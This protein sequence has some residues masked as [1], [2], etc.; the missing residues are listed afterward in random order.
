MSLEAAY[1]DENLQITDVFAAKKDIQNRIL[2]KEPPK[3]VPNW[4]PIL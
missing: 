3:K 4:V 1:L 2:L